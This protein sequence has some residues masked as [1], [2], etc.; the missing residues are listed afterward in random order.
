M[1]RIATTLGRNRL[2]PILA[3]CAICQLCDARGLPSSVSEALT[4]ARIPEKAVGIIVQ[5]VG[6][7]NPLLAIN[8]YTA[9]NPASTMKLVTTDAALELL[10]PTFTWKTQAYV[11]GTLAGDVLQGDLIIKGG[12]D[13]K[14]VTENFWMFLRQIRAGGVRDIRGKVI[15]DRSAFEQSAFDPAKFDGDPI[16]PYNV[17]PD[18]I[19]LNYQ[20]LRFQFKPSV[21]D[22]TFNVAI[23]PPLAGFDVVAPQWTNDDCGDW[24]SKLLASFGDGNVR[25]LGSYAAACG[26]K[27]WYLHPFRMSRNQ[28]FAAVFGRMWS[29][30]GGVFKGEVVDGV[31]PQD[32][33]LLTV[34]E[35]AALP[36]VIRDINKFSN[37]VMARQLLL[38]LASKAPANAELGAQSIKAW[39]ID[40][41]IEAPE[42]FIENGS[43]LSRNE[44]IAPA[45]MANL[46]L[47]AYRSP[48]MPEF[49]SSLPVVG[50]DGTMRHRLN[51]Q[52]VAGNA[53]IKTGTLN[54]VKAVAGYVLAASG[55]CY[56]VVFFINHSEAA[57]G[58]GAQDALLEWVF[59]HG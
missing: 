51:D 4:R 2:L 48:L 45:S 50:Y 29:D 14:L 19:M 18:A 13:P 26:E 16:K 39:L 31:V 52:G 27:T 8:Q 5:E 38:T 33:R 28:Y 47:A 24:Q 11:S 54:E 36:E 57:R 53:H 37:N 23:D 42:L 25:F 43:G 46:L 49:V 10:G 59:T 9:F 58:G 21:A 12:G 1:I 17:S 44:R 34:W 6:R 20:A 15:L 40:K 55:K 32:A 41:G 22:G 56:V 7:Q 30:L 35:S 3:L